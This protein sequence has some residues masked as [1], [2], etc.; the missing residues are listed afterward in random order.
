MKSLKPGK[1]FAK[2]IRNLIHRLLPGSS[3]FTPVVFIIFLITGVL[4]CI[5]VFDWMSGV[6]ST[7]IGKGTMNAWTLFLFMLIWETINESREN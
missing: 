7:D 3:N 6:D 5:F 2:I 4:S 1:L